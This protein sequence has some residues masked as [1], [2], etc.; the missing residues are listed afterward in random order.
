MKRYRKKQ[1]TVE[2]EQQDK[3]FVIDTLEGKM[4]GKAGD[5]LV[6]GVHGERYPVKRDIFEETYEEIG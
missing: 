6:I 1:I 5:Y 4:S 3:D 2:A